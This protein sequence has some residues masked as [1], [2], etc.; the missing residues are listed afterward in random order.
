M[1]DRSR[2]ARGWTAVVLLIL[3]ATLPSA[4]APAEVPTAGQCPPVEKSAALA[5]TSQHDR[6]TVPYQGP[7]A[8]VTEIVRDQAVPGT[9]GVT[10]DLPAAWLDR[11]ELANERLLLCEYLLATAAATGATCSYEV[12]G[13]GAVDLQLVEGHYRFLVLAPASDDVR[14]RFELRGRPGATETCPTSISAAQRHHPVVYPPRRD[15]L[16]T[17]LRPL[18]AGTATIER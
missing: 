3:A 18:I 6:A 9:I 17:L 2:R 12:P 8:Q 7:G 16:M 10:E 15:E 4:N 13:T 11:P 1:P 5:P 14:A